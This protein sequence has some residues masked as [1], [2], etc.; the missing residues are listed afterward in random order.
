MTATTA[1]PS[2]TGIAELNDDFG[3][4]GMGAARRTTVGSVGAAMSDCAAYAVGG[5]GVVWN[6]EEIVPVGIGCPGV[7]MTAVGAGATLIDAVVIARPAR[8]RAN[9]S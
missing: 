2:T 5:S 1:N 4:G 6:R 9:A 3:C 7:V 8:Q